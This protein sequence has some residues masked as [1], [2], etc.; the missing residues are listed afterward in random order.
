LTYDSE[1]SRVRIDANTLCVTGGSVFGPTLTD[2]FSRVA[3]S[4][5]TSADTGQAW[6]VTG[7]SGSDYNVAGGVGLHNVVTEG[8]FR[9]TYLTYGQSNVD[10]AVSLAT[11]KLAAGAAQLYEVVGRFSTIANYYSARVTMNTNQTI[12]FDV[13]KR[14]ADVQTV[15][16]TVTTALTHVIN[17]YYRVRLQVLGTSVRA[18]IWL[19]SASEPSA[20]T[21]SGTDGALT[22]GSIVAL[23]SFLSVA[24]SNEPSAVS[25]DNLN[26]VNVDHAIVDRTTDGITYTTVRG[27]TDVGI[28]TGCEL[29]RIV[30]DYEFPV[31]VPITYRVRSV[32]DHGETI[33]T[34]TCQIEVDLDEVWIKSIGRPFLNQVLHCVSNPTPIVRRARNGINPIVNRSYPV[35]VTDV[36]GSREVTVPVITQTTQE[37]EDLDLLLASGDPVFMHTPT[38]YPLP[39]MYAV[40]ED[41][42]ESRPVR[43]RLCNNDWR[44]FE[45]PLVEI[46]APGPDVVGS[47]STW[48]TV[49]NTYATWSAVIADN[50]TWADLLDLVGD[51]SEVIVP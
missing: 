51:G 29:E 3:S 21:V 16:S 38:G 24:T 49:L 17:T 23:R 7:G 25:W 5:W 13:R 18:K 20:W 30:D 28:T 39:T 22:S 32:S 14:V 44:M 50:A 34:T 12:T 35:A 26:T 43:N 42:T 10:V 4:S 6:S 31:G 47:T 46:A 37:R 40:I 36:R 2:T 19:A 48:Q 41:T 45:L 9:T 27:A 8:F 1:L 11:E 15:L 33:V